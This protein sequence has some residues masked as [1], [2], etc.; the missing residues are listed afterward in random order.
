MLAESPECGGSAKRGLIFSG[1][2]PNLDRRPENKA[3]SPTS[4]VNRE[5]G[6]DLEDLALDLVEALEAGVHCL[7]LNPGNIRNQDHVKTVAREAKDRNVPI[8]IGDTTVMPGDIVLS[9]PE[10]IMFIPPQLALEVDAEG[11][12]AAQGDFADPVGP[13]YWERAKFEN[14]ER[15]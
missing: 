5:T 11:Y 13:S 8:R 12:L 7:R 1:D 6:T 9:G 10:G 2:S 15:I 14:G 4:P 3:V